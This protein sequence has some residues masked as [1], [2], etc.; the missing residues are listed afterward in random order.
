MQN[1]YFNEVEAAYMRHRVQ[2][3][4]AASGLAAQATARS[5]RNRRRFYPSLVLVCL[6]A[7]EVLGRRRPVLRPLPGGRELPAAQG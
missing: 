4:V 5:T 1:V 7:R 6:R 3:A 2:D